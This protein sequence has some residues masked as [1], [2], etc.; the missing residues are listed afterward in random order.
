MQTTFYPNGEKKH[1]FD[2]KQNSDIGLMGLNYKEYWAKPH[3]FRYATK[4]SPIEYKLYNAVLPDPERTDS[5]LNIKLD[6]LVDIDGR[7]KKVNNYG[8]KSEL[9]IQFLSTLL[10]GIEPLDTSWFDDTPIEYKMILNL[11][12]YNGIYISGCHASKPI[13]GF[14]AEFGKSYWIASSSFKSAVPENPVEQAELRKKA[15]EQQDKLYVPNYDEVFVTVEEMPQFPGGEVALREFV[16][17]SLR[18]P[19]KSARNREQGRVYVQF[20]I[21]ADGS[22]SNVKVA[23]GVSTGLDAEA[24]RV[25]KTMPDWKPGYT[26]GVPKRV[27]YT[28]PVN[29]KLQ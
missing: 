26:A 16:K 14:T 25:I 5:L 22:V 12:F 6:F 15:S 1:S 29:F 13:C 4:T 27:T 24:V 18:Y 9:N 21:E 23:R 8:T 19:V 17:R 11:Y 28:I 7:V 3:L 2:F 20:V 10:N